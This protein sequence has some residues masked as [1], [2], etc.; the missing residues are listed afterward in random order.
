VRAVN[1]LPPD[2]R[3]GAGAP[4]RSGAAVYVVLGALALAVVLV[5]VAV[6]T[7]RRIGDREAALAEAEAEAAAAEQRARSIAHYKALAAETGRRVAGVRQVAAS[8][9]AWADAL[10][11]VSRAVGTKVAFTSLNASA[12]PTSATG[13]SAGASQLRGAVDAPA[14]EIVGCAEDHAAVARLM[15][16]FR[17]MDRVQRVSLASSAKDEGQGSSGDDC[18]DGGRLPAQFTVV[19][20]LDKPGGAG[21]AT[22]AVA[23]AGAQPSG[24]SGGGAQAQGGAR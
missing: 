10:T 14:L 15:A 18:R 5:A 23:G 4:A 16:R 17:A 19:I 3:R 9:V 13:G 22:T 7:D 20:W 21:T 11:Q 24:G 12:S 1:L 8:R 2:L 6:V